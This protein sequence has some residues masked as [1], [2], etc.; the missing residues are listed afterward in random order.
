MSFVYNGVHGQGSEEEEEEG[1]G[2]RLTDKRIL[3]IYLFILIASHS[4]SHPMDNPW[5]NHWEGKNDDDDEE[6]GIPHWSGTSAVVAADIDDTQAD[7]G[8][9]N[10]AWSTHA[11]WGERPTS[12]TL[13]F[14]SQ[15]TATAAPDIDSPKVWQSSY[16]DL[17]RTLSTSPVA[18]PIARIP[19]PASSQHSEHDHDVVQQIS[20]VGPHDDAPIFPPTSPE[21]PTQRSSSPVSPLRTLSP[22]PASPDIFGGF[23]SGL[24]HPPSGPSDPTLI[25]PTDGPDEWGASAWGDVVPEKEK[26]QDHV[27]EWETARRQQEQQDRHVVSLPCPLYASLS[28]W[29][30]YNA[31]T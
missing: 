3:F 1:G 9:S 22:R 15:S 11:N 29:S 19:S 2:E 7:I 18:S 4:V 14:W 24:Q 12:P 5:N 31:Q 27:D 13:N 20:H 16:D 21:A 10:P 26:Q 6:G 23:E 25:P 17:T 30:S 8:I 28:S